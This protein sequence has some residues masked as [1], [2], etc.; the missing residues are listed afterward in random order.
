MNATW[1][2]VGSQKVSEVNGTSMRKCLPGKYIAF[3]AA[4]PSAGV[5]HPLIE[6]VYDV[7]HR[8]DG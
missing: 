3:L 8:D 5:G 7:R 6:G 1:W 2:H 4:E